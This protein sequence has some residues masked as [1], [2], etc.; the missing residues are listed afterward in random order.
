MS[1]SPTAINKALFQSDLN[2]IS[3]SYDRFIGRPFEY[4]RSKPQ[5]PVTSMDASRAV[6]LGSHPPCCQ[7]PHKNPEISLKKIHFVGV[8]IVNG[9]R[10]KGP[11][12]FPDSGY[13]CCRVLLPRPSIR[14]GHQRRVRC[15]PLIAASNPPALQ[16]ACWCEGEKRPPSEFHQCF[17]WA[18]PR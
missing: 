8:I 5:I 6:L 18:V 17:S 11:P 7:M 15:I 9:T 1:F 3:C 14:P 4:Q 12:V 13:T 16:P 10:S 2:D